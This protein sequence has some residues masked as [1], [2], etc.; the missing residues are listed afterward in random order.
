MCLR[1][2]LLITDNGPSYVS[3]E[4]ET[5][6]QDCS[7]KHITSSPMYHQ[8]HGLAKSIVQVMK[9]L[10]T[11]HFEANEDPNWALLA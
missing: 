3:Q 8:S 9:N 11:K 4:F 1:H 10:I 7:I 5:F 2:Y 6:L